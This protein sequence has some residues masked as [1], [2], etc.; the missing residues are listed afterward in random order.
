[1]RIPNSTGLVLALDVTSGDEALGITDQLQGLI[2]AV[3]VGYPLILSTGKTVISEL[4]KRIHV[5]ADLKVADIPNTNRL[6]CQQIFQA[7][8]GAIITHAFTGRDSLMTCVDSA[9]EHNGMVYVV[10]EMSHPG[11]VEFLQPSMER[12]VHMAVDCNADGIIAPATRPERIA[13]VRDIVGPNMEIMCPGVGAQ[14]GSVR[15]TIINGANHIIV[16]R[17][18]YKSDNPRVAAE[19]IIDEIGRSR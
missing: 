19:R 7:G 6:I 10:V 12:M 8:A 5:I 17:S 11:A 18:I 2:D 15:E 16:G 13:V 14:G 1:M 3:K 4:S 9:R